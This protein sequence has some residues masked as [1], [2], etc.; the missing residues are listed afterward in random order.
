[1]PNFLSSCVNQFV[2]VGK[3]FGQFAKIWNDDTNSDFYLKKTALLCHNPDLNKNIPIQLFQ[4]HHHKHKSGT[5][6]VFFLFHI[7]SRESLRGEIW[8]MT[9]SGILRTS[10]RSN[11]FQFHIVPVNRHCS[12]STTI[13]FALFSKCN[14]EDEWEIRE[15]RKEGTFYLFICNLW[16]RTYVFMRLLKIPFF[17]SLPKTVIENTMKFLILSLSISQFTGFYTIKC[18][19]KYFHTNHII[20]TSTIWFSFNPP[21]LLD[22]KYIV[23]LSLTHSMHV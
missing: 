15:E 4:K 22:I 7:V 2:W 12:Y 3:T 10:Q 9:D 6:S 21:S 11:D 1:M 13:V 18:C 8:F 20:V 5:R 14:R 16:L 19:L 17:C 23:Q